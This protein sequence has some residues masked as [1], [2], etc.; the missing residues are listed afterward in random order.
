M[1]VERE[2]WSVE[3]LRKW[4]KNPRAMRQNARMPPISIKNDELGRLA[5]ILRATH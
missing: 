4:L 2:R 5:D 1:R 3:N